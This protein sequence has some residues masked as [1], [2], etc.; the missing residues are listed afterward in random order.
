MD[1][2]EARILI[3]HATAIWLGLIKVLCPNKVPKIKRQVASVSK[4]AKEPS[5]HNNKKF[6]SGLQHSSKVKYFIA[7][8]QHPPKAQLFILKWLWL[9]SNKMKDQLHSHIA[10]I[11]DITEVS[12]FTWR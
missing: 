2:A 9:N 5:D 11:G 1:R 7:A 4:K 6:L 3:I 10:A 8:P 12:Q